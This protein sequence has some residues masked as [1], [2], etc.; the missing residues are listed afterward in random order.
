MGETTPF[1]VLNVLGGQRGG[2]YVIDR[3]NV[4]EKNI[5]Y[6]NVSPTHYSIILNLV[7]FNN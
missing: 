2:R 1:T 6:Y 5:E 3:L 4:G 7:L